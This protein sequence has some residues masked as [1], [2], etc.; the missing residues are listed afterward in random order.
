MRTLVSKKLPGIRLFS[1]KPEV[2]RQPTAIGAQPVQKILSAWLPRNS[3]LALVSN[4]D[5]NLVTFLQPQRLHHGRGK[6]DGETVAPL[7]DLHEN[8]PIDTHGIEC[9]SN[10]GAGQGLAHF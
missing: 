5:V 4:V 1:V 7:G 9:I 3:K 8:L 2:S 6:A 10:T